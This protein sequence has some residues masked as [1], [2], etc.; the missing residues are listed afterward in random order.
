MTLV[1]VGA[2]YDDGCVG[3]RG[4]ERPDTWRLFEL[5]GPGAGVSG[6]LKSPR[7]GCWG[8]QLRVLSW[9][10]GGEPRWACGTPA[11]VHVSVWPVG[12]P[13]ILFVH[14]EGLCPTDLFTLRCHDPPGKTECTSWMGCP[15]LGAGYGWASSFIS[16]LRQ[17]WDSRET[18]PGLWGRKPSAHRRGSGRWNLPLP[19]CPLPSSWRLRVRFGFLW[20]SSFGGCVPAPR[21]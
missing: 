11:D 3:Q 13:A 4:R 16:F 14:T 21:S 8:R 6:S 9:F 5:L 10:L 1:R 19:R 17:A 18:C 20:L 7:E 15:Q 2:F 12:G